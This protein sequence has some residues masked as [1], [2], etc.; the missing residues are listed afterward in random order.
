[1]LLR[2]ISVRFLIKY[3]VDIPRHKSTQQREKNTV[4]QHRFFYFIYLFFFFFFLI[5]K[6]LT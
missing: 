5:D 1:M 4:N 6:L 2:T 3:N